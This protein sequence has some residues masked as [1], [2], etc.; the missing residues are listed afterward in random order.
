MELTANAMPNELK[1]DMDGMMKSF[2]P[3]HVTDGGVTV[4][5]QPHT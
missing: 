2:R 5:S 1:V 3:N 4:S